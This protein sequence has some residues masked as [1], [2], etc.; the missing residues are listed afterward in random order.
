MVDTFFQIV[1]LL[2]SLFLGARL[3]GLGVGYAGVWACLF[4]AYF[5][6]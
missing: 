1:V 3:G 5:W 2:F 6:G 4:Y